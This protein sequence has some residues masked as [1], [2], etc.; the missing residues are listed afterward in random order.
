MKP[1]PEIHPASDVHAQGAIATVRVPS[2]LYRWSPACVNERLARRRS[3]L[4]NNREQPCMAY[5]SEARMN[6]SEWL[7]ARQAPIIAPCTECKMSPACCF[8]LARRAVRPCKFGFALLIGDTVERTGAPARQ[9]LGPQGVDGS[10][11]A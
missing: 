1:E 9:L 2:R 7:T 8:C 4:G 3:S 11:Y 5:H 10:H 6:A